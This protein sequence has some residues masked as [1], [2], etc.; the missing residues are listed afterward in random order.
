MKRWMVWLVGFVCALTVVAAPGTPVSAGTVPVTGQ[1]WTASVTVPDLVWTGIKCQY[2]PIGIHMEGAAVANWGFRAVAWDM[3]SREPITVSYGSG[4]GSGDSTVRGFRI[5]P[6]KRF[7]GRLGVSAALDVSTGGFPE[8]QV[9]YTDFTVPAPTPVVKVRAVSDQTKL[10]VNVNPN[11]GRR[12]W[13]FQVQNQQRDG[14]WTAIGTYRTK[15]AGET[16]KLD[17]PG[18]NYRVWVNPK[19][20][21]SGAQSAEVALAQ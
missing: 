13:T 16:R 17:L 3:G 19:F 20:G 12:F 21:F 2:L 1:G 14:S 5:C 15:G 9:F 18:G 11:K 10:Y 4:Y 8:S 7:I 6:T